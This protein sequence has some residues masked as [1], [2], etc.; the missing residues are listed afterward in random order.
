VPEKPGRDSFAQAMRKAGPYLNLGW[1][2]AA[3][4][5][6]G[7]LGGRWLDGRFGTGPWL[8]LVGALAGM[9]VAFTAFFRTVLPG[10]N[11]AGA[12][13]REGNGHEHEDEED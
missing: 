6:A 13:G 10:K 2:F 3:S 8:L 12:G 9:A 5:A 1:T 7:V 4:L 11:N